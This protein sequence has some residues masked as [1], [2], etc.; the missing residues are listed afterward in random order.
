MPGYLTSFCEEDKMKLEKH[1][2]IEMQEKSKLD[3]LLE[4]AQGALNE[5]E[6]EVYGAEEGEAENDQRADQNRAHRHGPPV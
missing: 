5:D 4:N 2:H 3:E 6:I 1:S